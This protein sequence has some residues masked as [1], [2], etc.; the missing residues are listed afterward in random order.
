MR[1]NFSEQDKIADANAFKNLQK[2]AWDYIKS[3][4]N[5]KKIKEKEGAL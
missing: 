1:D 5:Y 4:N 2:M 3:E